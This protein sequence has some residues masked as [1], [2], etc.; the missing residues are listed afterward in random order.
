MA[1]TVD[2]PKE[3][4]SAPNP[5]ENPKGWMGVLCTIDNQSLGKMFM[6]TAVAF[7]LLAGLMAVLMRTQLASPENH[8][9]GPEV[10]NRLFTMHGS[11]MMY[12][13]VVPFLEG[14]G[15]YL[16][17]MMLGSRDVA[18]PYITAFSYWT[19][20]MGGITFYG[21]F[22]TGGVPN[23]GW[24]AY[25]PL[26]GPNYSGIGTDFWSLA[27]TLVS[28]GDLAA[29]AGLTVSV[30]KLRA[31]G[32]SINRMPLFAWTWLV[33]GV[34]ITFAFTTLFC[35]TTLMLPLDRSINTHF[36]DPNH[37]GSTLLWQHL[38]WF[39]GHPEVYIMFIPAT[40]IVSSVLPVFVHK[41]IVGYTYIA[42]AIVIT[43]FVSF[44]L[45]VH[46]M[47]A[48]GLPWLSMSF[49]TAAS[50]M[51]A[52]A[53]G[54]QVFAWIATLWGSRPRLTVP[55]LYQLGF[56][57]LFVVG[58][59]TGVMVAIVPFDWQVHDTYFLVAHFHYVLIGGVVFPTLGGIYYWLPKMTGRMP[60]ERLGHWSF[61]LAFI[62]FNVA[63]FPMHL[64]G[65]AGMPRRVYT[66]APGLGVSGYNLTSTIGAYIVAT[67]FLLF[68]LN[69]YLSARTGTRAEPDPWAAD[70]LEWLLASPPPNDNFRT[71]PI[72]HSRHPLWSERSAEL[73]SPDEMRVREAIHD[74]PRGWRIALSTTVLNAQPEA[75]Q[76]WPKPSIIPFAASA[77]LTVLL[78]GS[79]AKSNAM[80]LVGTLATLLIVAR[81]FRPEDELLDT[82]RDSGLEEKAG[83]PLV[84]SGP[85]T[86]DWWG[87]LFCFAV[88][89]VV[90]GNF[91]YSYFYIRLY[92]PSWPQGHIARP[93]LLAGAV[94]YGLL[95]AS[96]V[97]QMMASR[98][99]HA[100][101]A[102]RAKAGLALSTCLG[103]IVFALL[104]MGLHR[105]KFHYDTNAYG[106]LIFVMT[107]VLAG[108]I[109][110]ACGVNV[111]AQLRLWREGT[112]KDRYV[113]LQVERAAY[114]WALTVGIGVLLYLVLYVSPYL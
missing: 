2:R 24:F 37:G 25:P 23:V 85:K 33:T 54:I 32:M 51:I 101:N 64:M 82:L 11:T 1:L 109:A 95:A 100:D 66:Y 50:L 53:S 113:A 90:Y 70:S 72:V 57:A 112:R 83:L 62:G 87:M 31:P 68:V 104:F 98:A 29:G 43:A 12:L 81:W 78:L 39:F 65:F 46:H 60:S 34:M 21:S 36:F 67:G 56:V 114:F 44:G 59:L 99:F 28:V 93:D 106:S 63:F 75:L 97:P 38:F 73:G 80:M 91:L 16:L 77:T 58:G 47:F 8:F 26:A 96:I 86:M 89:G 103:A 15:I 71:P 42:V 92:S 40:G 102:I 88:L 45:W 7:F 107:W 108:N 94:P 4:P 69:A 76:P 22:L 48:T 19:Y 10:Y 61:W 105:M 41:P 52:I 74:T 79:I 3:A 9:L 110:A 20:L 13:V 111:G 6:G 5:W 55:M 27:L 14:L 30:I 49:F 17:P 35:I 84:T 18:F